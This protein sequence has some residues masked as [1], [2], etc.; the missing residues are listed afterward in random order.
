MTA[1]LLV[2]NAG[3]IRY[4]AAGLVRLGALT[5]G[6]EVAALV[7]CEGDAGNGGEVSRLARTH[8]GDQG[9]RRERHPSHECGQAREQQTIVQQAAHCS[10]SPR[11]GS[12]RRQAPV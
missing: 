10:G 1:P 11:F 2:L 6:G 9:R 12:A 5:G 8:S 3:T 7:G 4:V